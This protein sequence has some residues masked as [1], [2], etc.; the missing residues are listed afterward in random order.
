MS[1]TI[2][3]SIFCTIFLFG[4]VSF[5]AY[6]P[7][8]IEPVDTRSEAFG[9]PHYADVSSLYTLFS[10]PAALAFTES[11]TL[12]PPIVA[13][14][15]GGPLAK[16]N[17]I[18]WDIITKKLDTKDQQA[19]MNRVVDLIGDTGFNTSERIGGPLTFGAIRNN[20][21]WGFVN[22]TYTNVNVFSVSRS[23]IRAGSGLGFVAGY[24]L[25]CDLGKAGLLS[26]GV[27]GRAGVQFEIE[28]TQPVTDLISGSFNNIPYYLSLGAGFDMAAQY[29]IGALSLAAVWQDVYSPVWTKTYADLG[30]L[31][32]GAGSD[33]KQDRLDSKFGFGARFDIPVKEWAGNI[34][35]EWAVYADYNNIWPLIT[36]Q[37]TYRNPILELSFGTEVLL[38]NKVLALRAGIRD[39]YP[40]AGIGLNLGKKFKTD[41]SVF[42][43]ELGLEPGSNPQ[44]NAGFS[45]SIKY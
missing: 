43:K 19:L 45:M 5:F 1:K 34:V 38:F 20:F 8:R 17:E 14:G 4:C 40:A 12:W 9:G 42:G 30:A 25:P 33:F 7:Q 27:S 23:D 21:G 29:K 32:S 6:A 31:Q 22:T 3:I 26:I 36:K 35:P 13:F 10:N 11:K 2:K 16:M 41:F 15:T 37:K 39:M 28:Y 24:A 18:A 44:L